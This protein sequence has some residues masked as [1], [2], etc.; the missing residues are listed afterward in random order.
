MS[1]ATRNG[2]V[3][4]AGTLLVRKD[5]DQDHTEAAEQPRPRG[6]TLSH[7]RYGAARPVPACPADRACVLYGHL[8]PQPREVPRPRWHSDTSTG[9]HQGRP[10]LGRRLRTRRAPSRRPGP[11]RSHLPYP[12][13]LHRRHLS[14][15]VQGP[16]PWPRQDRAHLGDQLQP[17]HGDAP[18]GGRRPRPGADPHRLAEGQQ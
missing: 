17:D 18:G 13:R 10:L 11:H 5:E 14:T 15:V 3:L 12:S 7:P 16:P 1:P 6:Q 9:P 4:Y 8:G 2:I